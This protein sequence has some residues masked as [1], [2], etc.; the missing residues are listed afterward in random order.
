M[1][2]S[3]SN[4]SG[5]TGRS[6][7][8]ALLIGLALVIAAHL[9]GAVHA[10][11][12]AGPGPSAAAAYDARPVAGG[13]DGTDPAARPPRYRH[14]YVTEEAG[15]KRPTARPP[16]DR[17]MTDGARGT[18]STAPPSHR[19]A[20]A[21]DGDDAAPA[22]PFPRHRHTADG[23]G[24]HSADRPRAG[25]DDTGLGDET[26]PPLPAAGFRGRLPGTRRHRPPGAPRPGANGSPVALGRV[27]RQ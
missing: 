9:T 10:C 24:D 8:A 13:T 16:Q 6:R 20:A 18:G 14:R 27:L 23:H 1:I 15:E 19:R 12:F 7:G 22:G 5:G 21:A 17:Y 3:W 25:L 2:R 4:G 26:H 11:A